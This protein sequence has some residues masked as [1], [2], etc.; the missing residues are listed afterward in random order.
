MITKFKIFENNNQDWVIDITDIVIPNIFDKID[1]V[2]VSD[3]KEGDIIIAVY[4]DGGFTCKLMKVIDYDSD[5]TYGACD[6]DTCYTIGFAWGIFD[7]KEY[8]KYDPNFEIKVN[9][10]KYNI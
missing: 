5:K 10:K 7:I 1:G 4:F 2:D 8:K 6:G 3:V 9:S